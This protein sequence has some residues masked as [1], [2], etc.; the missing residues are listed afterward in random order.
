MCHCRGNI[1]RYKQ[2]FKI[3]F[4]KTVTVKCKFYVKHK[5]CLQDHPSQRLMIKCLIIL[6]IKLKFGNVGFRGEGKTRVPG[7]KPLGARKRTNNKLTPHMAPGPGFEHGT[8]WWDAS[9]FSTAPSLLPHLFICKNLVIRFSLQFACN[10]YVT[11]Y[12]S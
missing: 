2:A 12:T 6:Q 11:M 3:E 1:D 5:E 8:P 10:K 4:V 9:A 7:E